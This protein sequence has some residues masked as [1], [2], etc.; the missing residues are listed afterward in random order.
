MNLLELSS[1]HPPE[2]P[3]V[4]IKAGPTDLSTSSR[5]AERLAALNP[6]PQSIPSLVA[7]LAWQVILA[8]ESVLPPLAN[9]GL[10]G[11]RLRYHDPV[12]GTHQ[13]PIIAVGGSPTDTWY[14]LVVF[15]PEFDPS[16]STGAPL[17]LS[18]S[19][20]ERSLLEWRRWFQ[21]ARASSLIVPKRGRLRKPPARFSARMNQ[22]AKAVDA[23]LVEGAFATGRLGLVLAGT[24]RI[25]LTSVPSRPIAVHA[26]A[27]TD[28]L[29]TVGIRATHRDGI[30]GYTTALHALDPTLTTIVP[31]QHV[32]FVRQDPVTLLA[33]D[34]VT[35]SCLIACA[36]A[37]HASM[38]RFRRNVRGPL[39]GITP[40][41][42]EVVKADG[43]ASPATSGNVT[44]WDPGL[45]FVMPYAQLKV[46]TTPMTKPGD[47]GAA[48]LNQDGHILGF[49]A[50]RTGLSQPIEFSAWIWADSVYAALRLRRTQSATREPERSGEGG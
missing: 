38:H 35:D 31:G 27:E 15:R 6:D 24:P 46:Y 36:D 43:V 37:E 48:L 19:S 44:G 26:S 8:H 20:I 22:L 28:V 29:A 50:Y 49:A 34:P 14:N 47:S 39:S 7:T 17:T 2:A 40:R 33:S 21:V 30:R 12:L 41:G 16:T 5:A 25:A 13:P 4:G 45:P 10:L 23:D 1:R 18:R 11:R 9:S 32:G 3:P 42:A